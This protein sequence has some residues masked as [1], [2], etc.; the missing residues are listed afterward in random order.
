MTTQIHTTTSINLITTQIH[1]TTSINLITTKIH[2]TTYINLITTQINTT[3]SINQDKFN[4]E[5]IFTAD[6]SYTLIRCVE[7]ETLHD[8]VMYWNQ[9]RFR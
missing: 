5:D 9:G 1:T 2:T 4:L 6:L 8:M 3:T 7:R